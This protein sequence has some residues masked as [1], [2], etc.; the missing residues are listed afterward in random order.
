MLWIRGKL[1][2]GKTVLLANVVA[3]LYRPPQGGG[4]TK[5]IVRIIFAT[6]IMPTRTRTTA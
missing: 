2:S 3:E 5:P 1:G 6:T 4:N